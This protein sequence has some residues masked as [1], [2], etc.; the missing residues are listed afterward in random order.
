MS[1]ASLPPAPSRFRRLRQ[2][3]LRDLLRGRLSG[4]LDWRGRIDS[5]TLSPLI[6]NLLRRVVKSTR[7]W[8]LERYDVAGEFISHFVDGLSAGETE[9]TLLQHFGDERRTAKLVRR[10][11]IRI[12]RR[13]RPCRRRRGSADEEWDR[14]QRVGRRVGDARRE[15]AE[16]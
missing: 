16:G 3:P 12:Q 4:R 10:A 11:K 7:L 14:R 8:K 9:Q 2:T 6:K 13:R 1:D 5:S 15:S